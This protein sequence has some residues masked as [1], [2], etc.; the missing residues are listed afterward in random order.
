MRRPLLAIVL[1]MAVALTTPYT[2]AADLIFDASLG[3]VA[4]SGLGTVATILTMQSPGSGSLESGSVSRSGGAD[5]KSDTGVVAGAGPT[6]V[7]NVKTGASQT[8]T[9]TFGGNGITKASQVAIVFN[10]DE[11]SGNSIT[12]TGLQM[13]VFNGNT[14]IFDAH[15][16]ASVSFPT[17]FT[18]IGKEG[19]VFRLDTTQAA[20]LQTVLDGL[21]PAAVAALRLGLSASASDATG[22]PETFN[23]A[24]ITAV[25]V[26][27]TAVPESGGTFLFMAI[28]LAGLSFVAWRRRNKSF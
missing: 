24:T 26:T 25:P 3:G 22:G 8:L 10:A 17:T 5:V 2:A 15:L 12:L 14:D 1:G 20:A 18:G 13:S 4:G 6:N 21:T 28:A 7:G 23:V 27:L 9:R 16:A 11:P 19:F